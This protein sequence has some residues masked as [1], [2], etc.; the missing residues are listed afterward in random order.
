M[1]CVAATRGP[2]SKKPKRHW[3]H[4]IEAGTVGTAGCVSVSAL[5]EI[6]HHIIKNANA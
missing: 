4:P 1:R 3:T 5:G 6:V 2:A